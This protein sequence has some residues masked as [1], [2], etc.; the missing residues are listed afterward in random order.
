MATLTQELPQ[1]DNQVMVVVDGRGISGLQVR[2]WAPALCLVFGACAGRPRCCTCTE[3]G[4]CRLMR[5]TDESSCTPFVLGQLLTHDTAVQ[6]MKLVWLVKEVA[7]T[8]H[9]H[10]P[11][12]MAAVWVVEPPAVIEWPLSALKNLLGAREGTGAKIRTCRASDPVLP[13]ELP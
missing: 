9:A 10:F 4:L 1:R 5:H 2:C 12:R 7:L 13:I 8:L 11:G 6:A 3:P